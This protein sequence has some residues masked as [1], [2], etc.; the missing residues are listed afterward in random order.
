MTVVAAVDSG[1]THTNVR[2][3]DT[4]SQRAVHFE[5]ERSLTNNRSNLELHDVLANLLTTLRTNDLGEP[6][7]IWISAAGYST[8]TRGR[9]EKLLREAAVEFAG[10]IGLCN[11]AATLL[12]AHEPGL[13]AVVCGT[14]SVAMG[15]SEAGDVTVRGGDEW[16]V[17]DYGS[18]FWLGLEG[19]RAA[20]HAL[21]GG[22]ETGLLA[23]LVEHYMPLSACDEEDERRAVVTEIARDLARAGTNTKPVIA[24]FARQVTRQAEL[25]D[26]QAQRIV[27]SA[28]DD[29]ATAA[30]RVYRQL[31]AVQA[32]GELLPRFLVSGSVAFNSR[33]YSETLTASI[34]QFLFDVRESL[35]CDVKTTFQLNGI[36]EGI[37]LAGRLAGDQEIPHLDNRHPFSVVLPNG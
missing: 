35:S 11:D 33:F 19:I 15:R 29:L 7:A 26:D 16:V 9:F 5:L 24:S 18:A 8:P 30:V 12:L 14:G 1:G 36:N 31:A 34:D 17:A 3:L 13:V 23:S 27:R 2:V 21:E 10:P 22:P 28:A 20:Y 6:D 4:T 25:G 37:E 32:A